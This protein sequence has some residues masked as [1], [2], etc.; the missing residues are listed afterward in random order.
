MISGFS[1]F[2]YKQNWF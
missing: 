2:R 1:K